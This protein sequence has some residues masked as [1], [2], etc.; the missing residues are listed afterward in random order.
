MKKT[1]KVFVFLGIGIITLIIAIIGTTFAFFSVTIRNDAFTGTTATMGLKLTITPKSAG[2]DNPLIPQ[3]TSAIANAITGTD[4]GSCV[5]ANG[6]TV[7]QVYEIMIENTGDA[8][9]IIT[10][11]LNLQAETIADLKWG[12]GTT[13]TTGFSSNKIYEITETDLI[14]P[15][16]TGM[17]QLTL[18]ANDNVAKQGEDTAIFYVVI[19]IE[20]TNNEQSGNN[21]GTFTG[22]VN[23]E[24]AG[25]N[26][27]TAT[28]TS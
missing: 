9:N 13:A 22:T 17:Q 5:D 2:F 4:N 27:V 24:A 3:K 7:C 10:A 19:Y 25:G 18:K 23:I 16:V 11:S 6:N 26:G 14:G 8:G 20:E 28:F 12:I 1:D 21:R 15:S